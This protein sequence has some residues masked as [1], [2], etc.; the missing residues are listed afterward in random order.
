[1]AKTILT[2]PL[3]VSIAG[4]DVQIGVIEFELTGDSKPQVQLSDEGVRL[5]VE[6]ATAAMKLD[7]SR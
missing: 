5:S 2:V 7:A 4:T 6:L 3:N 1:V